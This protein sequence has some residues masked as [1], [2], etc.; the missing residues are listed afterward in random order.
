MESCR[1]LVPAAHPQMPSSNPPPPSS[2][3]APASAPGPTPGGQPATAE[4]ISQAL[5]SVKEAF[6]SASTPL[7]DLRLDASD[8]TTASITIVLV[9]AHQCIGADLQPLVD[10]IANA[11]QSQSIPQEPCLTYASSMDDDPSPDSTDGPS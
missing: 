2:S 5:A 3:P 10:A 1:I 11:F 6:P 9:D 7:V 8:D 4:T